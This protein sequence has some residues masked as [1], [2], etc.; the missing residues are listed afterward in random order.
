MTASPPTPPPARIGRP[1]LAADERRTD[2]LRVRLT[3][4]ERAHIEARAAQAGLPLSEFARRAITGA[5]IAPPPTGE[6]VPPALLAELGRIGNNVN[7]IAHAANIG[8]E[9]R[10]L[11]EITLADLRELVAVITS[12]LDA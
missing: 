5:K 12:K 6:A 8:R 1:R 9:L 2:A 4:D 10:G 3:P 11:A 7:Q